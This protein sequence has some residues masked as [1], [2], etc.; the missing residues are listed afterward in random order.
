VSNPVNELAKNILKKSLE[1]CSEAELQQLINQYPYFGPARLLFAKKLQEENSPSLGE[2][3]QTTSLYFSN[4]LWLQYL[5]NA[6]SVSH[7]STGYPQPEA[8]ETRAENKVPVFV[9]KIEL[10]NEKSE[11]E[12]ISYPVEEIHEPNEDSVDTPGPDDTLPEESSL[13]GNKE[14]EILPETGNEEISEKA[15]TP[16]E[17]RS[18][19]IEPLN[20]GSELIF[21]PYHTV[22]YFAS[23]GIK[24]RDDEKPKDQF[25]QQLKSFTEWL[26]MM[27]R[28]PAAG[29]TIVT[30]TVTE[31][32]VEQLAEHS[33]AERHVV[34]EAMAE[35]WTK[36]GNRAKA[37]EIYRKLSLL[38]PAKSSYFAA[39]IEDLKKTS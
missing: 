25:S 37:E 13:S 18:L 35:V 19:K 4:R 20:A 14:T 15:E 10:A 26:K 8:E 38:D 28:I 29:T 6:N 33:L 27:K 22:D 7:V 12:I 21:E 5:L 31:K 34:T 2:E 9:D 11:A 36:Q 39:K 17:M 32:R 30:D 1:E 3:V 16:I 23:Q 24:F